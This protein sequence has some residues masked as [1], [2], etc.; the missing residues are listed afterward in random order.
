MLP[1]LVLNYFFQRGIYATPSYRQELFFLHFFLR[2]SEKSFAQENQ[3]LLGYEAIVHSYCRG[4]GS[5]K[6]DSGVRRQKKEKKN[7]ERRTIE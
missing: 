7:D 2:K 3:A 1:V 5:E 4:A 6:Q